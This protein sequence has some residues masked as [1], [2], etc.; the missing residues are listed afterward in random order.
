VRPRDTW[1]PGRGCPGPRGRDL[2]HGGEGKQ[3]RTATA[4]RRAATPIG[5]YLLLLVLRVSLRFHLHVLIFAYG[6]D[7]AQL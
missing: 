6:P 7:E 5:P 3:S 1:Q 2:R 4:R